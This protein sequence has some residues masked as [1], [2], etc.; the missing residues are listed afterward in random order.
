MTER[1]AAQ[2]SRRQVIKSTAALSAI[3]CLPVR[4]DAAWETS[5]DLPLRVQEIYP[6]LHRGSLW[7]AG[8]LSPDVPAVQQNISD[9]VHR[10]DVETGR[11]SSEV[12]LP[13]PRHHGFLISTDS[14]LL[15]FGGF[16]AANGGRWSASRDVLR[17]TENGWSLIGTLPSAQ[18]ETVGAASGERVHL[19]SGRAPGHTNANWGD[20]RD[21]AVHQVFDSRTGQTTTA[22]PLPMARN[23]AASFVID[24]R[25]HVVGGRTVGGGNS[26]RHDVYDFDDDTWRD[27]APLPQAQGGLAAANIGSY[28]YV[29]GG[30]YFSPGGGG[31]YSEVWEYDAESDRW[32]EAGAMPV[33][34]HGLGAVTVG[35]SIYVVAGATEAGGAGTSNRLS[36]FTPQAASPVALSVG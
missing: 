28:G 20:Q 26:A 17:L 6:C 34:R 14:E 16:L 33:P 5:V 7:V 21:I 12:S 9:S 19:A 31:V 22:A 4:A 3:A 10:F 2:W 27:A 23:S 8:G 11:W 1:S 29:F 13:E 18:S 15:L 32:R 25:W 36:V 35:A 24:G 30:E